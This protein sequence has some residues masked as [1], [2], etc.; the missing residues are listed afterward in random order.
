[1]PLVLEWNGSAVWISKSWDGSD[2]S[3]R[4]LSEKIENLN[5]EKADLIVCGSHEA[6]AALTGQG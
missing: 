4:N 6:K 1:M 2:L 5:L 3:Y